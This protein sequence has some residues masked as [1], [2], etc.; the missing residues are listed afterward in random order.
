MSI[1]K[2]PDFMDIV[3]HKFNDVS[4]TVIATYT[5]NSIP[6]LDVRSED[7]SRVY[8]QTPTANWDV[9]IAYEP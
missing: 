5:I 1:E 2:T 7:D 8:W 4:G 9:I 3:K 6:Y